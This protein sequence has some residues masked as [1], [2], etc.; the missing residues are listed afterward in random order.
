M[1]DHLQRARDAA[2]SGAASA[3]SHLRANPF[4]LFAG[5]IGLLGLASAYSVGRASLAAADG[6]EAEARRLAAVAAGADRWIDGL[7]PAL[8]AESALW[9]E[10]ERAVR[11]I[12]SAGT[13]PTTI[14]RI[15]AA[16]AE[17]AGIADLGLRLLSADS[18]SPPPP[19][20][21]GQWEIRPGG[22]AVA[23]EFVGDWEAII[24]LVG[25]LPPQ[26]AIGRLEVASGPDFRRAL[27]LLA[28][29]EVSLHAAPLEPW[30][31]VA[32]LDSLTRYLAPVEPAP[33]PDD[34]GAF[35]PA[36]P[37]PAS[38]RPRAREPATTLRLSAILIAGDRRVAIINDRDVR[39]GDRVGPD[40]VVL[41]IGRDHVVIRER[42]GSPRTLRLTTGTQHQR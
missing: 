28:A 7:E 34:Y 22:S 12:T 19:L 24:A 20:D 36:R 37:A 21:A 33:R 11:T 16:R 13:D 29:R 31:E 17:E 18:I 27:V 3:A 4:W 6:H 10:S 35:I 1:K 14:A 15:V 25:S 2:R 38:P 5:T 8:P 23:A 9:R 26:V 40:A 39:Q 32:E 42:D 30:P 41:S